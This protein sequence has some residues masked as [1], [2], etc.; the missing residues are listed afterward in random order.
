MRVGDL[1]KSRSGVAGNSGVVIKIR[2]EEVHRWYR[3]A[4]LSHGNG[5]SWN[6]EHEL[7]IISA[8]R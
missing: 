7:E 8:S 2:D 1:V 4:W 5:T 3:V 6:I